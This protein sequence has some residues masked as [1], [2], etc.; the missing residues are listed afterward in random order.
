MITN[1]G[2]ILKG[3]H[4]LRC[5]NNGPESRTKTDTSITSPFNQLEIATAKKAVKNPIDWYEEKVNSSID[6]LTR[7]SP[8]EYG[9]SQWFEM[10][11][12]VSQD[13]IIQLGAILL[14]LFYYESITV[15]QFSLFYLCSF[16]LAAT[17]KE[18]LS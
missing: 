10:R 6:Q 4:V 13:I 18:A 12:T 5:C 14:L 2:D 11:C 9:A 17:L 1:F 3:L 15:S 8:I 7:I 16:D